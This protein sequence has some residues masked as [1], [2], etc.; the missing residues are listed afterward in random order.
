MIK[1]IQDYI[2]SHIT[3]KLS[4]NTIASLFGISPNYL[5]QLFKKTTSIGFNEY[6]TAKKNRS[7]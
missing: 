1:T 3:D 2:D 4:L 6:I 5:S 7:C